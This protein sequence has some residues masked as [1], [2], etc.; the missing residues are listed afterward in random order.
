MKIDD[1][2]QKEVLWAHECRG[3]T[4]PASHTDEQQR[5]RIYNERIHQYLINGNYIGSRK[6]GGKIRLQF[7]GIRVQ[8]PQAG[9][10]PSEEET[11]A[12][13]ITRQ[14][15]IEAHPGILNGLISVTGGCGLGLCVLL[16]YQRTC[17]E[18]RPGQEPHAIE[19]REVCDFPNNFIDE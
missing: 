7:L 5:E 18:C 11:T 1:M 3:I 10:N 14:E 8:E 2:V 15:Q 13:T 19:P 4:A 12:A 6:R 16:G 17:H 9:P